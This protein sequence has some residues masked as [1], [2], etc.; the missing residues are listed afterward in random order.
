MCAFVFRFATPLP[1]VV[2]EYLPTLAQFELTPNAQVSHSQRFYP[3]S[4]CFFK[5]GGGTSSDTA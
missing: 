2:N 1:I 4:F 5:V 3:S